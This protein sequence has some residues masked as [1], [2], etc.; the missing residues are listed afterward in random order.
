MEFYTNHRNV[1]RLEEWSKRRVKDIWNLSKNNMKK[2]GK[3]L[4]NFILII[5]M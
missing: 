2:S 3:N 5:E 1:A 4:W